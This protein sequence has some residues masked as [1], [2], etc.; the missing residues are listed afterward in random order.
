MDLY[1]RYQIY[2]YLPLEEPERPAF[3]DEE[4]L[5]QDLDDK[6]RVKFERELLY[7]MTQASESM[8][9]D[10]MLPRDFE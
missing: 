2:S 3:L 9:D 5:D 1:T 6:Q 10:D 4:E 8:T 7:L